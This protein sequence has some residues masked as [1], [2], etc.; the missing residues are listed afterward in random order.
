MAVPASREFSNHLKGF[1]LGLKYP[2]R[3]LRW[4]WARRRELKRFWLAPVLLTFAGWIGASV[5][6]LRYHDD[7]ATWLW[8]TPAEQGVTG[9]LLR[10]LHGLVEVMLALA[11]LVAVAFGMLVFAQIIAAPFNDALSEHVEEWR[12]GKPVSGGGLRAL[13]GD[14]GRSVGLESAKLAIYA[15]IMMPLF[16]LSLLVPG[17]GAVLYSGIGFGLTIFYLALDYIDWPASRRG[18]D[19]RARFGWVRGHVG[20]ALGFGL[21]AWVLL[22]VPVLNLLLMP[23]AV[24]GGTLLYLDVEAAETGGSDS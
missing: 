19:A 3:G 17:V 1:W 4:V 20:V 18:L 5:V 12:S 14:V 6:A 2:L 9:T 22:F 21:G 15:T 23:A 7:L 13:M 8:A 24:C 10:W 11:L 16:L